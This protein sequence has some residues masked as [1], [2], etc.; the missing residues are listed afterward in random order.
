[1]IGEHFEVE[2]EAKQSG[3]VIDWK[4]AQVMKKQVK[5]SKTWHILKCATI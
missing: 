3:E 2:R 1:M 5:W 4:E